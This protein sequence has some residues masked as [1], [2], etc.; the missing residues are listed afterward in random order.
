MANEEFERAVNSQM[1]QALRDGMSA[2]YQKLLFEFIYEA[3]EIDGMTLFG[4][5]QQP[6]WHVNMMRKMKEAE[7]ELGDEGMQAYRAYEKK[8]NDE[9]YGLDDVD[10]GGGSLADLPDD[11]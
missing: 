8:R 10:L 9:L 2:R 5:G 4:V 11:F 3:R 1:G 6:E 7:V